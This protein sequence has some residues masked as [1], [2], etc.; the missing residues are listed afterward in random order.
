MPGAN[1]ELTLFELSAQVPEGFCYR[2]NFLSEAEERDL[3]KRI[4]QLR[5]TPFKFHQFTGKRRTMSFGWDYEFGAANIVKTE[6]LPQFL[7]PLRTRAGMLFK[8]HP[9][10]LVQATVIEYA[11][12]AP[13]GWHRDIPQF[14]VVVGISLG[15]PCR[16]KFRCHARP[17]QGDRDAK[18]SMAI[19]LQPRSIYLLS[20]PARDKWQ[21]SIPAVKELRYSIVM[22]TLGTQRV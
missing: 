5:L 3:I 7:L 21:H 13:I 20:G 19:G 15:A 1:Q 22:R 6:D 17:Q 2:Q 8:I 16:L 18:I 12:G 4:Q 11:P 10:E 9:A 14:G